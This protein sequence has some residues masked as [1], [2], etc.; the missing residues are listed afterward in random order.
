MGMKKTAGFTMIEVML[1][2][3]ITGLMFAGF[4]VAANAGIQ[5][6]Q[7]RDSVYSLQSQLKNQY[8]LVQNPT[9]DRTKTD[10]ECFNDGGTPRGTMSNCFVVGRMIRI[11]DSKIT[12][13][14]VLGLSSADDADIEPGKTGFGSVW[15]LYEHTNDDNPTAVGVESK[16]L[17]WGASVKSIDSATAV[18]KQLSVLIIMSPVNGS[19]RTYVKKG[20]PATADAMVVAAN[21]AN[22]VDICID[23]GALDIVGGK[24][25][26]VRIEAN[27]SSGAGVSVP[28]QGDTSC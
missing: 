16:P 8:N 26:A 2:L 14:P 6:Q 4:M 27:A 5:R 24:P 7:Y 1:V 13:G 15:N 12:T 10:G 9:N 22:K 25:M 20:A 17:K 23:N 18:G 21:Q 11:D 28:A 19:L 3:A